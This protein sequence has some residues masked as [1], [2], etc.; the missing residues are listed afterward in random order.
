VPLDEDGAMVLSCTVRA[1]SA[2]TTPFYP[3]F[4]VLLSEQN[5]RDGAADSPSAFEK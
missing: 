4:D 1:T 3:F 2:G 5:R